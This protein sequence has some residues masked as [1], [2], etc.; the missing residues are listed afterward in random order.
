MAKP[1]GQNF[2]RKRERRAAH[3]SKEIRRSAAGDDPCPHLQCRRPKPPV[4]ILVVGLGSILKQQVM[5]IDM[6]WADIRAGSA[7]ARSLRKMFP[8]LQLPEM[9]SDNRPNW[10]LIC[11]V[12]A[13][14]TDGFEN[15]TGAETCAAAD[16]SQTLTELR[17]C[18]KIRAAVVEED[19]VD[20][21]GTVVFSGKARSAN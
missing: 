19:H 10:T 6:H 14:T 7:K 15:G 12:V 4:Q 2:A 13:V 1:L 20:M 16:A 5:E 17:L 21:F 11:R 9:R 18:V 3:L 8:L